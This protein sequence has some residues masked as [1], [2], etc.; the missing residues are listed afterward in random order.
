M[1][2]LKSEAHRARTDRN[3]AQRELEKLR[4]ELVKRKE[5]AQMQAQ[6]QQSMLPPAYPPQVM[7][8]NQP[9]NPQYFTSA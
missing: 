9:W 8:Q 2:E 6:F 7:S 1:N 4:D 3:D 5:Y